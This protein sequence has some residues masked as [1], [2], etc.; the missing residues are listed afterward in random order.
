MW[1]SEVEGMGVKGFGSAAVDL[2][3][4]PE[5]GLSQQLGSP[6]RQKGA[7]SEGQSTSKVLGLPSV[8]ASAPILTP[9]TTLLAILLNPEM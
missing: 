3:K 6:S 8:S 2:L 4:V 9:A 7:S 1:P 5:A